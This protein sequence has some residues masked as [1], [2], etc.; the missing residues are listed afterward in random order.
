MAECIFG[1][2]S[3]IL[4]VMGEGMGSRAD[5][6]HLAAD[7]IEKLRQFINAGAVKLAR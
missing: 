7:H 2:Q 4:A 3:G 5:Q 6:R 1:N